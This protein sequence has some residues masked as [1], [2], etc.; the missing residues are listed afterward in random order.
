MPGKLKLTYFNIRGLAETARLVLVD[1]GVDFEDHRV[2]RDDWPKLKPQMQFGQMPV[3]WDGDFQLAQTGAIL[4]YLANTVGKGLYGSNPKEAAFIDMVYEGTVDLRKKYYDLI[5]RTE[6]T[7][8][9][10]SKFVKE[11]LPHDLEVFE[12]LLKSVDGG[13]EYFG[14]KTISFADY[15]AFELFDCLVVLCPHSLDAYPSLKAFHAR[16]AA[17]PGL[18]AYLASDRR[19]VALNGNG[20]Q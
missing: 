10:K 3:L 15:A 1:N 20:K 6:F 7:D 18:T 9:D 17:R 2:E 4:R 19:K 14:G 12:K 16:V 8:A 5:Y 13:K 11:T